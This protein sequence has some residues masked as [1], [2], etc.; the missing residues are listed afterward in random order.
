MEWV[1]NHWKG[2]K[3]V[4][5]KG[6]R[7]SCLWWLQFKPTLLPQAAR[8]SPGR[9]TCRHAHALHQACCRSPWLPDPGNSNCKLRMDSLWVNPRQIVLPHWAGSAAQRASCRCPSQHFPPHARLGL[10]KKPVKAQAASIYL[11]SQCE[12]CPLLHP[13][14]WSHQSTTCF[15]YKLVLA[16]MQIQHLRRPSSTGPEQ[17]Q[18]LDKIYWCK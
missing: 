17:R 15:P 2:V 7:S 11:S 13:L 5:F 4:R 6:K 16:I 18:S 8:S 9:S 14:L 3:S 12:R 1:S 10:P